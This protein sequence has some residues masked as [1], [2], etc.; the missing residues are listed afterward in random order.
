VT[1]R[2]ERRASAFAFARLAR[3]AIEKHVPES[4]GA[5]A[6]WEARPNLGWVRWPRTAGG[7]SYLALRRH[8]GW[9]TGEAGIAGEPV[10]LDSLGLVRPGAADVARAGT[11]IPGRRVRLGELLHEEDRWW[12]SGSSEPELS[13]RLEW[14]VLQLHARA[15]PFFARQA[16]GA[17]PP[18]AP[19]RRRPS[20]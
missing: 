2:T 16:G 3:A 11:T 19:R 7:Y 5:T 8:L 18:G 4:R 12:P 13:E 9:V 17:V 20:T 10:P 15:E 14:L 6:F 1:G